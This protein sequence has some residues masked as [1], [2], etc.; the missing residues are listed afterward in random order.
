MW[1]DDCCK[2]L[3]GTANIKFST[4]DCAFL[5]VNYILRQ[6]STENAKSA[7]NNI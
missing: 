4:V 7:S 1:C 2:R 5:V 6:V 3:F